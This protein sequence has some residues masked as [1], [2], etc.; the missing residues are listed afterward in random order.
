MIKKM[1]DH[2]CNN[3]FNEIKKALLTNLL[4]CS[5]CGFCEWVC[6]I[7]KVK[8]NLRL[9]GPRGRVN[10][11]IYALKKGTWSEL[12]IDSIYTCLLCGSCTTQ[13]PAGIG[14]E[15]YIRAFRYYLNSRDFKV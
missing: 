4:K 10:A 14:I 15:R 7:L 2:I 8:N 3:N 9:Y 6:P 5:Y 1:K 13:C 12:G 11:I